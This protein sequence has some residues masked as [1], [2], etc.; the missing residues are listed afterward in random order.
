MAKTKIKAPVDVTVECPT[1]LSP[2][3]KAR[4][5]ELNAASCKPSVPPVCSNCCFWNR[6][7]E[8]YGECRAHAPSIMDP[9]RLTAFGPLGRFILTEAASWCGDHKQIKS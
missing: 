6:K 9:N 3:E 7:T 5:E 8:E 1:S 4:L 2:Q